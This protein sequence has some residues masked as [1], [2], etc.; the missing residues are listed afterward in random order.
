MPRQIVSHAKLHQKNPSKFY[1]F[2]AGGMSTPRTRAIHCK[3]MNKWICRRGFM[4]KYLL[5]IVQ[6]AVNTEYISRGMCTDVCRIPSLITLHSLIRCCSVSSVLSPAHHNSCSEMHLIMDVHNAR[7][8][9]L[10]SRPLFHYRSISSSLTFFQFS[11]RCAT[12]YLIQRRWWWW[13]GID[14]GTI[15]HCKRRKNEETVCSLCGECERWNWIM[16]VSPLS[17]Y[18]RRVVLRTQWQ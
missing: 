18:T 9:N 5:W 4:N 14:I 13:C 12:A 3:W 1:K 7:H 17:R 2:H 8:N 10:I 15:F 11:I 16:T 6:S